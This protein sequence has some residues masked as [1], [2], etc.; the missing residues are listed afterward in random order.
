MPEKTLR[1]I[2]YT[3]GDATIEIADLGWF[4]KGVAREVAATDDQ[5]RSL[6][7]KGFQV[8][9]PVVPAKIRNEE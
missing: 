3:G 8:D 6:A 4:T 1:T 7:G 5:A 2:T 9:E